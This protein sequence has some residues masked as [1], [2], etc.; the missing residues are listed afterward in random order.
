VRSRF[1]QHLISQD[2]PVPREERHEVDASLLRLPER[3]ERATRSGNV[4]HEVG[5]LPFRRGYQPPFETVQA[6]Q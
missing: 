6:S 1:G 4:V 3:E 2:R 5:V